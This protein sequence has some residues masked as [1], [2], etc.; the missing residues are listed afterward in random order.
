MLDTNQIA[1]IITDKLPG[2]QKVKRQVDE[3]MADPGS[4]IKNEVAISVK[5][6][7]SELN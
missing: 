4:A 7:V 3:S 2:V 5:K 1:G 6:E